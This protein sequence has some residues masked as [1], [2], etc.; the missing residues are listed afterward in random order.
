MQVGGQFLVL[1]VLLSASLPG[2]A[3]DQGGGL[4]EGRGGC[5]WFLGRSRLI[6]FGMGER[7]YYPCFILQS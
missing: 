7:N 5:F 3:D 1:L 6:S 4:D 2:R